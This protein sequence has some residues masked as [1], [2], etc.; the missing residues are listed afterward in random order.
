MF[1]FWIQESFSLFG[2]SITFYALFILLGVII[3]VWAG[4]KEGRKLGIPSDDVYWGVI[5]VLPCAII[6][7]RLWY[8]L[9]NLDEGWTFRRIIG[10]DGGLAGLAIQGGVIAA[11][12]LN[13][14]LNDLSN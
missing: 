11:Y 1:N 10:L 8:I 2:L 14:L 5:I 7:A 13:H 9:F 3:A 12:L 4:I 6:G